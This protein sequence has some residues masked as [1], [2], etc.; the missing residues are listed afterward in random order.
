MLGFGGVMM[1]RHIYCV[2]Y[3]MRTYRAKHL[4]IEYTFAFVLSGKKIKKIS[5]NV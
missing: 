1:A 2:I 4:T 3:F 5:K